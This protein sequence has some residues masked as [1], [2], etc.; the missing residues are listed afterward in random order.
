VVVDVGLAVV[1]AVEHSAVPAFQVAVTW[2]TTA[3]AIRAT[4]S[5][6]NYA[7]D[8]LSIGVAVGVPHV[9]QDQ[10]VGLDAQPAQDLRSSDGVHRASCLVS[11]L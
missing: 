11:G 8:A 4:A 2:T 7:G 10:Q 3:T 1:A 9:D 5:S 6:T